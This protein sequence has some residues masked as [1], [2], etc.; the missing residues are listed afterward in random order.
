MPDLLKITVAVPLVSLVV[1]GCSEQPGSSDNQQ[2]A[3]TDALS[4]QSQASVDRITEA[5]LSIQS[6]LA[7]D[8]IDQVPA[9]LQAIRES[10]QS[11]DA[12][13]QNIALNT[14]GAVIAKAADIDVTNVKTVRQKLANLSASVI[15]LVQAHPPSDAAANELY[16]AQCPMVENGLWLQTSKEITNPYMGSRMLQC[17][18]IKQGIKDSDEAGDGASS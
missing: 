10:A 5:Y 2:S 6:Q 17:G 8:S 11:L 18:S 15:E 1:V 7:S 14:H 12:T 16:L 9:Q 4:Q 13:Q 3:S